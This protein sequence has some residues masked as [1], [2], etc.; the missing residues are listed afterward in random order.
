MG[1]LRAAELDRFGMRGVGRIYADYR[2]GRL[3]ADDAVTLLHSP[4]RER[5]PFL[6]LWVTPAEAGLPLADQLAIALVRSCRTTLRLPWEEIALS[7]LE[8]PS[9]RDAARRFVRLAEEVN[10]RALRDRPDLAIDAIPRARIE[11]L[12]AEHWRASP[13]A[14]ELAALDRDFV[15]LDNE[16]SAARPF[17][18]FA[19]YNDTA[20]LLRMA[21]PAG[22]RGGRLDVR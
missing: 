19:R 4:R 20:G 11:D 18:L 9:V 17:Y 21:P 16:V 15:S 10:D 1:A 13:D 5:L 22:L 2:D 8:E 3:E 12:L 7:L 14:L 6:N